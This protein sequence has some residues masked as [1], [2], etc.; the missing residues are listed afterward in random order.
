MSDKKQTAVEWLVEQ[1]RNNE[2]IR[3]RGTNIIELGEQAE[4]MEKE[5]ITNAFDDGDY[6]Y[7]YNRKNG[8]D[9]ENGEDYFNEVY[10]G[11][12]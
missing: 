10:G 3:W 1:L 6:N 8:T 7:H 2:N 11:N 12:K 5:N 4:Q 9:F